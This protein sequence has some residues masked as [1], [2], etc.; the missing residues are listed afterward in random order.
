L[1]PIC[2]KAAEELTRGIFAGE[3][4]KDILWKYTRLKKYPLKEFAMTV[5]LHKESYA[6]GT[7]L[8][9]IVAK[10]RKH[11]ISLE[12]GDEIRYVKTKSGYQ[13]YQLADPKELDYSYYRGRLAAVLARI[14]GPTKR[15]GKKTIGMILKEG[16]SVLW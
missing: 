7:M 16:Q 11:G 14:L 3:E 8:G 1:P 6:E 2:D 12:W 4:V 9:D 5:Q 10:A 15:M 13:L